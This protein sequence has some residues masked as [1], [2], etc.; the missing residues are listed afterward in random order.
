MNNFLMQFQADVLGCP[1]DRSTYI[2]S[3]GM[4]AAFLAG[5]ATGFWE[6]GKPIQEL[7]GSDRVFTPQISQ[8]ERDLLY[9][10]W[11]DAVGRVKSS[12]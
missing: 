1:I 11:C 2:E 12:D 9:Q 6:P 4:G 7:R 8:E 3:T 5:I 10:G